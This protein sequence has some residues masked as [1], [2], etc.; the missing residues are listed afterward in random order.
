MYNIIP[1]SRPVFALIKAAYAAV[2]LTMIYMNRF[3]HKRYLSEL[4]DLN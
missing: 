3:H 4:L 1:E 2:N